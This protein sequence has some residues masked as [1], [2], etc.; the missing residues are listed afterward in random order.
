MIGPL[1]DVESYALRKNTKRRK[2]PHFI[3]IR[4]NRSAVH[5]SFFFYVLL[6]NHL[7]VIIMIWVDTLSGMIS[8]FR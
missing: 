6:P 7:D 5:I 3:I 1:K 2:S 8:L 4:R